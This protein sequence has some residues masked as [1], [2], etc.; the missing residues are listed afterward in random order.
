M[1]RRRK[2]FSSSFDSSQAK[3]SAFLPSS[4][5]FSS[6]SAHSWTLSFRLTLL[7][8]CQ[9]I[10]SSHPT[11]SQSFS[12]KTKQNKHSLSPWAVYPAC[13]RVCDSVSQISILGKQLSSRKVKGSG[14]WHKP[15]NQHVHREWK[16]GRAV[17]FFMLFVNYYFNIQHRKL[18]C[19]LTN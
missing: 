15:K 1:R 5:L 17:S 2:N 3:L 11:R 12:K 18:D 6:H 8:S 10:N 4:A 13:R 16:I 9:P 14:P 7:V 19:S